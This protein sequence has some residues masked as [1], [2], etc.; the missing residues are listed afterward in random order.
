MS[1]IA[2]QQQRKGRRMLLTLLVL[3]SLPIL[4]VI[5]MYGL[6]YRPG[7]ASHG[8]LLTPPKALQFPTVTDIYGKPFDAEQW[9][10]KW[11][12][13]MMADRECAQD[14]QQRVHLL[15]QIHV[16]LNKEIERVQRALIVT[17][18]VDQAE[19]VTLQQ[20]YPDLV[21]LTGTEASA[22]AEQFDLSGQAGQTFDRTYVVDPLGNLMMSYP[23]GFDPKGM[24]K[25]LTR[26]LKYSWVG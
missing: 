15:R 4:V 13:V 18:A 1:E 23:S 9:K 21:I 24:Q 8:D 12:L 6:D 22:L 14:C 10:T 5:A 16:T 17:N 11:H 3:F 19:L 20:K 25:D 7:G 26:L 2:P